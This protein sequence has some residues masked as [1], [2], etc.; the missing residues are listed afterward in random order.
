MKKSL[1]IIILF[2]L[3]LQI[4]SIIWIGYTVIDSWVAG[5]GISIET[6]V[7]P[8]NLTIQIMIGY[9][10][11][12]S[13]LWKQKELGNKD[14]YQLPQQRCI[15]AACIA[16]IG[17]IIVNDYAGQFLPELPE[18][19]RIIM[20]AIVQNPL[21]IIVVSVMG[22]LIEELIFRG[23]ILNA[24]R[25]EKGKW[26]TILISAF[27]FG[28]FHLNFSQGT[29]AFG[30]GILLGWITWVTGSIIPALIIHILNNSAAMIFQHL[31][32]PDTTTADYLGQPAAM[33]IC[34]IG[35]LLLVG[36]IY[37]IHKS[38]KSSSKRE[39]LD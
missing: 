22:P 39:S 5:Q 32:A 21:G 14:R 1:F 33:G 35:I 24:L 17:L 12:L 4:P 38:Y 20:Q 3:I 16:G 11:T 15:I 30:A 18:R 6:N 36:S 34:M 19:Q 8:M 27:L 28:L 7:S 29:F 25:K 26:A 10:L 2:F 37:F 9:A 31:Y 23:S 13:Y